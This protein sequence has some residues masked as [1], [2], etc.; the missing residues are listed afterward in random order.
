MSLL[1]YVKN[2]ISPFVYIVASV[3]STVL[4]YH[5]P[6]F[7]FVSQHIALNLNGILILL[8]VLVAL[9][10]VEL[11]LFLLFGAI[12]GKWFRYFNAL[13]F[14]T[15]AIAFYFIV[16]Y[17]TIL[18]RTMMGNVFNTNFQ[19][20]SSYF[21]I[22]PLVYLVVLGIVPAWIALKVSVSK[23][24]L[25]VRLTASA[26][27]SL[28][29]GIV[30]LYLN[31]SAWLWF[32]KYAKYIGGLTLPWSYSINAIRHK[33]KEA[34]KN[35][36]YLKL[37]D[38]IITTDSSMIVVLVIGESA[39]AQNF[40]L[41]GYHRKTNPKLEKVN[42]LIVVPNTY[43]AAT[44]TTASVSAMLSVSGSTFDS[45]E[46]L[47]NYLQR[48]GIHVVWRSTNWGE[49]TLKVAKVERR[50]DLKQW[51]HSN[52]CDYD[53]ILLAGIEDEIRQISSKKIFIVLHTSGSHGPTY[54]QKYPKQFTRFTPECKSVNLQECSQNSLINAYDNTIF[55]TDHFLTTLIGKLKKIGKPTLMLYLSDH[56]ESLGEY[57]F[58]LHGTPYAIA[59]EFQKKIPFLVYESPSFLVQKKLQTPYLKKRERYGDE[60]IFHTVLGA[61]DLNTSIY[62]PKLDILQP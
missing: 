44:Y 4:L 40:S 54:Y 13:Q 6:L 45:Y 20:S 42:N 19:E 53:G 11:F 27:A 5:Y 43:A 47:P 48:N 26:L 52:E 41:Y 2:P 25:R 28:S 56:G 55:Y 60:I 10:S 8:S 33:L 15:N 30:F 22:S 32:D 29:V 46:P 12:L 38:A 31:S 36:E 23:P 62:D 24:Y 37:S 59:P 57:H 50:S 18:D 58:Y 39:R 3:I 34:K 7:I 35:K 16:T 9:L 21:G 61:F 17:H 1:K 49:P 51:C 14:I